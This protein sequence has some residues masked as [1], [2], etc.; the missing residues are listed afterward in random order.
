M[1][2]PGFTDGYIG[3]APD[4]GAYEFGG[5]AWNAGVGSRPTLAVAST[6]GGSLTLTASPD[7]AYY[8][9][10]H[11]HES[12]TAGVWNPVTNKPFVS[13]NQWSVTLAAATNEPCFYRLQT[14]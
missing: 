11:C 14:Q 8:P 1:V 13:G 6:G 5:L 10:L 9:A 7:A 4:L 12:D 3:S 2:I